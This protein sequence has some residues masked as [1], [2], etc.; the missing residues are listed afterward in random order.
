MYV[1]R[2]K[3]FARDQ[4][5]LRFFWREETNSDVVVHQF[6]RHIFEA[7]ASPTCASFAIRKTAIDN[8]STHPETAS[9]VS[10]KYYLDDYLRSFV[11]VTHATTIS[12]DMV[13]LFK[14]R[15]FD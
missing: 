3:A 7:R 9:L 12:C 10:E 13:L 2:K 1:P 15:G 4:I 6:T 5:L 8:M 11:D 14:L